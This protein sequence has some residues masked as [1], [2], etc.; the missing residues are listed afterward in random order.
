M[1]GLAEG[2]AEQHFNDPEGAERR[3][4]RGL[5][6]RRRALHHR[7]TGD[8]LQDRP[9][10]DIT[11]VIRALMAERAG[12]AAGDAHD[13][14]AG[15]E[16]LDGLSAEI[17]EL[18]RDG[19]PAGA[20]RSQMLFRAIAAMRAAGWSRERI[21]ATL[22]AYPAGIAAKC[23][24]T[25]RDDVARHVDMVLRKVDDE[26]A[27]TTRQAAAGQAAARRG[28]AT[29][30]GAA[31]TGRGRGCARAAVRRAARRAFCF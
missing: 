18:I 7:V 15:G 21:I 8:V 26:R 4:R 14:G 22:R 11:P 3:A 1:V 25:G 20:D 24:D 9:L 31:D 17:V 2:P 28:A 27:A 6:R 23:F 29:G 5:L 13:R 19:A 16:D 10:A 30:G 12:A